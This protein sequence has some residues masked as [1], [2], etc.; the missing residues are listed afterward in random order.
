MTYTLKITSGPLAG[1]FLRVHGARGQTAEQCMDW[2]VSD[3]PEWGV[4]WDQ[5]CTLLRAL[6]PWR[7]RVSVVE[8]GTDEK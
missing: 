5:V 2:S 8:Y 1:L 4:E 6:G 3:S 7:C